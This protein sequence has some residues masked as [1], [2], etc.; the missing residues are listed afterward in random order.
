MVY[1]A[2]DRQLVNKD[3]VYPSK[4]C[5]NKIKIYQPHF[6]CL[7]LMS[8]GLAGNGFTIMTHS[9]RTPHHA[10]PYDTMRGMAVYPFP[11]RTD[12]RV[13]LKGVARE[14]K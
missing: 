1:A 10:T 11:G 3:R 5:K 4:T 12:G 8:C 6:G 13:H 14:R 7:L 9:W 2:Q